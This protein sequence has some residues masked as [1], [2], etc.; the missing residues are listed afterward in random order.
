MDRL[1]PLRGLEAFVAA[2]ATGSFSK[3]ADLLHLT[4]SAFSRRIKSV[5]EDLGVDLFDRLNREIRLTEAGVKLYRRLAPSF[6]AIRAACEEARGQSRDVILKLAMPPGFAK[7]FVMPR[8]GEWRRRSPNT[9][10]QFDTAPMALSRIGHDLDAG[11]VYEN[12]EESKELYIEEIGRFASFPV[13]APALLQ[14]L[15]EDPSPQDFARLP[16]LLLHNIPDVTDAW[17]E[18]FGQSPVQ[19]ISINTFNSGPVMVDA[20]ASG[21]GLGFTFDFLARPY[22]NDGRLIRVYDVEVDSQIRYSFV[23]Q[24]KRMDDR[25]IRKLR[26]WIIN[27]M[28][29]EQAAE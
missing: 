27:D 15:G 2:G 24:R 20:A 6:D 25:V 28:P 8:I 18:Q 5:E 26:S 23:C 19:P 21:M 29:A 10:L 7:A 14:D 9:Q 4:P 13:I 17:L 3:A 1:P 22:L 16:R 11:V 12:A